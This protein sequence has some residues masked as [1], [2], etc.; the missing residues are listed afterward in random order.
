MV[1]PVARLVC[2][3]HDASVNFISFIRDREAINAFLDQL[4]SLGLVMLIGLL[5]SQGQKLPEQAAFYL[6]SRGLR[7]LL[8]IYHYGRTCAVG[9]LSATDYTD[10]PKVRSGICSIRE[11]SGN[12]SV[13]CVSP[14]WIRILSA[15]PV[16][17]LRCWGLWCYSRNQLWPC[18]ASRRIE[19]RL[20]YDTPVPFSGGVSPNERAGP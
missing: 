19:R 3:Y 1:L 16:Q 2:H 9:Q 10:F 4:G 11:I 12:T 15:V 5:G 8:N 18:R 6:T 17:S 20:L 7:T 14:I 13:N